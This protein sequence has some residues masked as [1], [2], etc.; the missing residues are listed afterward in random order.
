MVFFI[1]VINVIV[2]VCRNIKESDFKTKEEMIQR[3]MQLDHD[4]GQC[5]EYCLLI[6]KLEQM[7]L[8]TS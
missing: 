3:I 5:Q 2:C 1:W 6:Q 8:T 4:C 7:S